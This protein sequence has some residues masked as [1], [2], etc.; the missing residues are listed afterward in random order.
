MARTSLKNQSLASVGDLGLSQDLQQRAEE[1]QKRKKKLAQKVVP[2]KPAP[3]GGVE[4]RDAT[5][6]NNMSLG[7]AAQSLLGHMM[8]RG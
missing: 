8:G 3:R 5:L 1:E 6:A 2:S 4:G 7:A